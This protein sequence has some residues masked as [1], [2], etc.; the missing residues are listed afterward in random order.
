MP[1]VPG[2]AEGDVRPAPGFGT[3]YQ[4]IDLVAVDL[5]R[6][7][8]QSP[9]AGEALTWAAAFAAELQRRDRGG[10]LMPGVA[11]A[12]LLDLGFHPKTGPGLFQWLCA[13]GL[14]AHAFEMSNKPLT[15]L[16][17]IDDSRYIIDDD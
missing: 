9:G 16:P 7:L 17:F 1:G 2:V 8:A 14:L 11:A 4:G 6:A 3:R 12:A 13:P 15:A 5:G 10:W